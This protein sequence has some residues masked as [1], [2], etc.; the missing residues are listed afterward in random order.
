MSAQPSRTSRAPK[1]GLMWRGDPSEPVPDPQST[2]LRSIF[3]AA[4][5]RGVETTAVIYADEIADAVAAQLKCLDGVMVWID[6]ISD[7]K[8]RSRLDPMLREVAG[9]GVWVS[10]HPEVIMKM[11]VK[12]VLYR[13]RDLGWGADTHLYATREAFRA[14]FPRRLQNDGA[15]VLKPNR[16]N[17]GLGV[18]RVELARPGTTPE[19]ALVDVL[20]A[21]R[22]L[23]E[24]SIPLSAFMD[25]LDQAFE[26]GAPLIDQELQPTHGMV[27]CYVSRNRVVGFSEQSP[28]S[29]APDAPP[30]AATFAMAAG[31]I[32]RD[33]AYPAYQG[34]RQSMEADWIPGLQQRLDI[35]TAELPALWDADFLRRSPATDD[36]S[37]FVLCEIN[38][39]AVSPFPETAAPEIAKSAEACLIGAMARRSTV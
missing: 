22:D 31:K 28:R 33:E 1:L 11:G 34:L 4:A 7:G 23:P 29:Q 10:A 38:I 9:A 2:R 12:A 35:A 17:G 19:D 20:A 26:G 24:K 37:D 27:R 8:D 18:W 15:R 32:M 3:S 14:E 39:S 16:G 13:T 30:D 5:D 36:A 25:R 6:P 21:R